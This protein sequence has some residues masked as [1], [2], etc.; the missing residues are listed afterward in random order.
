MATITAAPGGGNWTAGGTW[1][2]GVAP[3]AADD[4]LLTA[5]SGN[6]TINAGSVC[7]SLNCT[8]YTGTLTHAGSVTFTI[9]DATAGLSNVALKLV[10]GMTYTLG[11]TS[12]AALAFVSTSATVQTVDT[13]GFSVGA[14]NFNGLGGSWQLQSAFHDVPA[15]GGAVLTLTAGTLDLNGQAVTFHAFVSN[16][17]TVRTLTMGS[18]LV[19]LLD[20][21][22]QVWN[23]S[24]A[25]NFTVNPGTSSIVMS[26]AAPVFTGGARTYND[27]THSGSGVAEIRLANTFHNLTVSTPGAGL[28]LP[29]ATTTTVTGTLS[30]SGTSGSP[31]TITAKTAGSAATISIASGI[32][33]EDWMSLKDSAAT[34]GATF[35]AGANTVNVSGNTGWTFTAPPGGANVVP[36]AAVSVSGGS[37]SITAPSVIAP[38]ASASVSGESI[39][40]TARLLLALANAISASAS[41]AAAT[42]PTLVSPAAAGSVSSTTIAVTARTLIA[43]NTSASVSTSAASVTSGGVLIVPGTAASASA[44]SGLVSAPQGITP[45]TAASASTSTGSITGPIVITPNIAASASTSTLAVTAR[46]LV[47][48]NA[49]ASTSTTSGTLKAQTLI[50][51]AAAASVSDSAGTVIIPGHALPDVIRQ[52]RATV[53]GILARDPITT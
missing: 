25:T 30:W 16:F 36:A 53:D 1:V 49:A 3:T 34:G 7:R 31:V 24:T 4:A 14:V 15:T 10:A 45:A 17:T 39:A 51:T 11:G 44:S 20:T 48:P 28:I 27:L 12:S 35:Y 5:T 33:S 38:S 50:Q 9:G 32:V 41:T 23:I 18:S 8:G 26:G 40:V 37:C 46:P 2:G 52:R 22:F 47:A 42:A 19:T 21:G 6:V 43:P 29:S 13:A